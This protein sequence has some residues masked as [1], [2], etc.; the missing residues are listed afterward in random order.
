[1]NIKKFIVANGNPTLL[2]WDCSLAQQQELIEKYLDKGVDQ[3]G[4]V[5]QKDGLPYLQM[6][7]NELCINGTLAFAY[8]LQNSGKLFT[9]GV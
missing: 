6:M 9:S 2:G 8:T 1:M 5:S 7:G 4:F 3:I